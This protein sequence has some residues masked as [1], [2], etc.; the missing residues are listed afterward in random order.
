MKKV[1]VLGMILIFLSGLTG[2]CLKEKEIQKEKPEA[3]EP[4]IEPEKAEIPTPISV[5]ESVSGFSQVSD[6]QGDIL[7]D[8]I[9]IVQVEV[10]IIDGEV[11]AKI[12]AKELLGQ[13][14]VHQAPPNYTKGKWTIFF[15]VDN[16]STTGDDTRGNEGADYALS[17]QYP[18][19]SWL[20]EVPEEFHARGKVSADVFPENIRVSLMKFT[21]NQKEGGRIVK[22]WKQIY[23]HLPYI[24]YKVNTETNEIIIQSRI[25]ELGSTI[26][27]R[28]EALRSLV[29]THTDYRVTKSEFKY[30]RD[31]APDKGFASFEEFEEIEVERAQEDIEW[32]AKLITSEAGSIYD[33][34]VGK[35]VVCTEQERTA[36]GWT[37][38][39]RLQSG[40][41][42]NTIEEVVLARQQYALWWYKIQGK[43]YPTPTQE[44]REI[45]KELLEGKYLDPTNGAIYFFS[46]VSMPWEGQENKCKPPVSNGI[47]DCNGGLHEV[48]GISKKVY[49]SS[50]ATPDK[51]VGD[52]LGVRERFFKFYYE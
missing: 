21:T 24:S 27:W 19:F 38:L 52:L 12:K 26:R 22:F 10:K 49:F 11:I 40:K 6:P 34:L 46:P 44:I 13:L 5:P 20:E 2:G 8:F 15:D 3:I 23:E 4:K 41:W 42:G 47:M 35:Y 14:P 31:Q 39:N 16:N 29:E 48:Q 28:V 18:V 1:F 7:F 25:P 30:D 50:W 32:L 17:L 45:A 36:V 9:D 51:E 43:P 37:V 33:P